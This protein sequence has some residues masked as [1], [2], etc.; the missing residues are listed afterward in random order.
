MNRISVALFLLVFSLPAFGQESDTLHA[1]TPADTLGVNQYLD[2]I[3]QIQ[4]G[5]FLVADSLVLID[6]AQVEVREPKSPTRA[7]MY[8]L[9]L[10]GLGQAYNQKYWK[11]PIVWG[12]LGG[13]AFAISYNTRLYEQAMYNYI[14]D[15]SD[16]NER[17]VSGWKRNMELSYIVAILVYGL[18]VLDAYVDANMYTW[19]VNDNL[20][21]GI[22]PSVQPMMSHTSLSGYSGGL[23]CSL[24]I[25]GR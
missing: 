13:A 15:D 18:Q 16:T 4:D 20:S 25:R 1:R 24:K 3:Y 9:V 22:S 14:L 17:Y 12:A 11:I 21:L 2:S 8:A 5:A 7:L 6:S 23:T 10:P 19:D